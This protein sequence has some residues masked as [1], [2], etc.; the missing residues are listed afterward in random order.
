MKGGSELLTLATETI[1]HLTCYKFVLVIGL[2]LIFLANI[3]DIGNM[4]SAHAQTTNPNL[5]LVWDSGQ[6][7]P[8]ISDDEN[9]HTDRTGKL[10]YSDSG[11]YEAVA[12][13]YRNERFIR[14]SRREQV[15]SRRNVD[16]RNFDVR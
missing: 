13:T 10:R 1:S 12:T 7:T 4:N 9:T 11:L 6:D 3:F 14:T 5:S 15:A 8:I 2:T 16:N